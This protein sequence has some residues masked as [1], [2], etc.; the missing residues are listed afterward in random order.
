MAGIICGVAMPPVWAVG[1]DEFQGTES[2][3]AAQLPPDRVCPTLA[4]R[5]LAL[6]FIWLGRISKLVKDHLDSSWKSSKP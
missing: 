2:Y 5:D 1:H 3:S 6:T 4:A